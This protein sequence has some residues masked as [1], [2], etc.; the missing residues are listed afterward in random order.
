MDVFSRIKITLVGLNCAFVSDCYFGY[1]TEG[2]AKKMG[3]VAKRM[4]RFEPTASS[5]A[6]AKAKKLQKSGK[7]IILLSQGEP[8]FPT[9]ENVKKAAI[10]ALELNQTKY[11]PTGGTPDLKAAIAH[12]FKRDNNL[13]F[14]SD[15]IIA[16]NGGK[17]MIFSA[18]VCT[19]EEGDEAIISAPYW[20]AYPDL[21]KF[22]KG[23]PVV[24]ECKEKDNFKL[25]PEQLD[26]VITS[27]TKWL[28]LN[29]PSN[30]AGS[31][32]S[33]SE[34]RALGE[35][36]LKYPYVNVL[37]DDI[38]EHIIFDGLKFIT[39]AEAVP[40]LTDR[41][42]T[43][44]GVSK[45]YSMTGWRL[46]YAAGSKEL[47]KQMTKLQ[48]QNTGNPCSI[49]QAAAIEALTGPQEFVRERAR[50]FQERRDIV[51]EMI[52]QTT[53]LT[54]SSPAGAFYVFPNCTGLMGRRTKDGEIIK[55]DKDLVMY[56]LESGGV[57]AVH[58]GA[59]GLSPYLRLSTA[60]SIE[61]LREAC[62]RIQAACQALY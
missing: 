47:I 55:S 52:R 40:E 11:T 31:L 17:Q 34:L 42:L 44:N 13:L 62:L 53:G 49:S 21:V 30:P 10:S 51:V 37:T 29:S 4:N 58:G 27:R 50:A 15:Q 25:Q 5:V 57:A 12:K 24:I 54:C 36:L 38:Y 16:G 33:L 22:V 6:T 3:I 60:A 9:P 26:A 61:N 7:D 1:Y 59:Y 8:D 23:V 56:L 39:F 45:T 32:Y 35:V 28:F 41:I 48:N 20:V 14:S 19:V 2:R 18:M 46:G 43:I